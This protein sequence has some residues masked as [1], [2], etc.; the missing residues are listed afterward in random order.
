MTN[1]D[2]LQR[3]SSLENMLCK[4]LNI[5]QSGI[6][7]N[8]SV[9]PCE[10][11]VFEWLDEWF[12]TYKA[13]K[14]RTSGLI[15]LEVCIRK[16]IKGN[17][18]DMPLQLL[19]AIDVQKCVNR[20]QSMRMRKY[21]YDIFCAALRQAFK[22]DYISV[23]I[24]AKTDRVTHQRVNGRALTVDEQTRFVKALDGNKYRSLFI[25][26]LLTGARKEEALLV[27]WTDVDFKD[28]T[29]HIP[30]TKTISSN[31]T[32][33]LFPQVA[34]LLAELPR[35]SEYVFPYPDY[36]VKNTF[37]WLKTKNKFTFSIH[38]LRHTFA[39]RCREA[40]IK[41]EILQH[42]LGHRKT[43]TTMDIYAHVQ[44]DADKKELLKF[45][46]KIVI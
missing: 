39:T 12:T 37:R 11:T 22:L 24:A 15:Q 20:I 23:D 25:F 34:Q 13:P 2:I 40:N 17:M 42:W 33:P 1:D 5:V 45:N 32:I 31:R 14:L 18:G 6:G 19:K 44:A 41:P 8:S 7:G 9:V 27:R 28:K 29:L 4:V 10:Y 36:S 30:G 16:H 38:S 21:T 35:D 43:S 3:L 26:Y 46:P